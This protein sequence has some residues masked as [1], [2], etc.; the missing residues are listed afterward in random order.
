MIFS[1]SFVYQDFVCLYDVSR[2]DAADETDEDELL[3]YDV[4]M[5]VR[6]S[7]QREHLTGSGRYSNTNQLHHLQ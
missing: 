5:S 6:E 4:Q 2:M 3:D 7:C 1:W